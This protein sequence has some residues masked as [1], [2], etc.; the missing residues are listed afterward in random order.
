MSHCYKKQ[1][2]SCPRPSRLWAY[3]ARLISEGQWLTC[4][5][6][7][8]SQANK[9]KEHKYAIQRDTALL[10]IAPPTSVLA[11]WVLPVCPERA[12]H[13]AECHVVLEAR[14]L[15]THGWWL[16]SFRIVFLTVRCHVHIRPE[17]LMLFMQVLPTWV[18]TSGPQNLHFPPP[19]K[20]NF[21]KKETLH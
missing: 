7:K 9:S 8:H 12:E 20:I 15:E 18:L 3:L 4:P 13:Q 5:L 11:A 1:F 19:P 6:D 14:V 21:W 16:F 2:I 10:K 17:Q